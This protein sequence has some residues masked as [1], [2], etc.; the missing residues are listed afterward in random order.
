VGET[1]TFVD[2]GA[3]VKTTSSNVTPETVLDWR[4]KQFWWKHELVHKLPNIFRN[5]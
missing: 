2:F 1:D 3:S 5:F 4:A